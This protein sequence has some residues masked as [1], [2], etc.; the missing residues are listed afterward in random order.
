MKSDIARSREAAFTLLE[1][2]VALTLFGIVSAAMLPAFLNQLAYTHRSEVRSGAI[3]VAQIALEELRL[4]NPEDLPGAGE[5]L[6]QTISS[7]ERDYEVTLDFCADP[8]FCTVRS[9]FVSATVSLNNEEV[10][11]VSTVYTRLR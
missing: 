11:E 7:G 2:L 1:T 8:T 5:Q 6:T 3:Q 10:Y 9:R 4:Q